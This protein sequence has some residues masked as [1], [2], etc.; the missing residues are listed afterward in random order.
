MKAATLG[1]VYVFKYTELLFLIAITVLIFTHSITF[2]QHVVKQIEQTSTDKHL[3]VTLPVCMVLAAYNL[4]FNNLLINLRFKCKMSCVTVGLCLFD[5][6]NHVICYRF[7]LAPCR[8]QCFKP[9]TLFKWVIKILIFGYTIDLV[10]SKRNEW[11]DEYIIG[12]IEKHENM[13]DVFL[14]IY[15][16]QHVIFIAVRLPLFLIYT[17]LTCCCY[18]GQE[19]EE[20]EKFVDRIIS[21]DYVKYE[22]GNLNNFRNHALGINEIEFNR[23]L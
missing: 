13:L 7:L 11:H 12:T 1:L 15:I 2:L 14:L 9:W 16:L 19:Y 5:C 18:K 20:D 23:N 10:K 6:V 3:I 21:F 4:L 17:T 22:L 8:D